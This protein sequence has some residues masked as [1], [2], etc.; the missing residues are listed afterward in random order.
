MKNYQYRDVNFRGTIERIMYTTTNFAG[1]LRDKY[2]NVYLPYGYDGEDC[3]RR[4][5]I[6]YLMH[7][8]GGNPDCWIDCC[9]IKN[10]LDYVISVKEVEPLIVV[11]PTYYKEKIGRVGN[12]DAALERNNVMF[13]Q[14]ELVEELLPAVEKKYHT[15]AEDVT[16]EKL[17]S[18][19]MHR[20]F[21][22]FSMGSCTTWFAFMQ[23]MNYF[24]TYVPLS[25]DCWAVECMGGG[26]NT[27][28]TVDLL[29]KSVIESGYSPNQYFIY[30]GT[31]TEDP[32]NRALTP[33]IEEMKKR[34]NVFQFNEDFAKGNLHFILAEG[35]VHAY[36]A[37]YEYLYNYLPYL[38]KNE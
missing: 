9:K 1:E 14:K 38:F 29:E 7:G 23:H 4:Y 31:G 6:L 37:V 20:G 8:G 16:K 5:N 15:Y 32:A 27:K 2:A 11:F 12:P 33:Q 21:G 19:R 24:S 35:A 28:E 34:Q 17:I 30:A 22:G 25:G 10:M 13:F 26:T 3:E 18:S 36:E